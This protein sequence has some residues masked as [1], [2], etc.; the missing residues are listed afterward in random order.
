[1]R[2]AVMSAERF[3]LFEPKIFS[4]PVDY[5]K[6]VEEMVFAGRYAQKNENVVEKYFH[7]KK[8]KS[9]VLFEGRYFN[10]PRNISSREVEGE[11]E[12][13]DRVNPWLPAQSEHIL[14]FGAAFPDEQ[15]ERR[16]IVGLGS[17]TMIEEICRVICLRKTVASGRRLDLL[18]WNGDWT[19]LFY[20]LAVR[21]IL[22]S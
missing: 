6:T 3:D 19:S 2:G 4:F 17:K 7:I 5:E 1:M 10:Y 20:F 16:S 8:E 11:I 15:N 21:P 14:A 12:Q 22:A 18:H 13:E 9:V